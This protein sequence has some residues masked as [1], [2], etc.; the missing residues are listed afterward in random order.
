MKTFYCSFDIVRITNIDIGSG[1]WG[2]EFYLD[3]I[4]DQADPI[5]C[6]TFHNLSISKSKYEVKPEG[7]IKRN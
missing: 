3:V 1:T 6:I 5:K 2:C 4:S 7:K